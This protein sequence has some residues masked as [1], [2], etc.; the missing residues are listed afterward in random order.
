MTN[1]KL[2][3]YLEFYNLLS[4]CNDLKLKVIFENR[5]TYYQGMQLNNKIFLN[6]KEPKSLYLSKLISLKNLNYI[7]SHEI[8]HY[9]DVSQYPKRKSSYSEYIRCE[10]NAWKIGKTLLFNS[11]HKY[12]SKLMNQKL[13]V[14]K[15]SSFSSF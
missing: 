1:S 5:I 8:G 14:I 7:F 6:L 13:N 11:N 10:K 15:P 3:D 4:I 9:L 12:F 2:D